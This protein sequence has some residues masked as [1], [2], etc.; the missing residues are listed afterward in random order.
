MALQNMSA[1]RVEHIART[2]APAFEH[3]FSI[4]QE[5]VAKHQNK[6]EVIKLRGQWVNIDPTA[7]KTRRDAKISVGVGAGNKD[8]MLANLNLTFQK[9]M[10]LLPL[11]MATP[12]SIHAT[13]VEE[14]KLQGFSNPLK[15]WPDPK[16]NPPPPPQ[17]PPE[18]V[19]A[20]ME[21]QADQQ[22]FQAQA[23]L[24]QQKAQQDAALAQQEAQQKLALEREKAQ[25]QAELERYKAELQAQT[26]LQMKQMELGGQIQIKEAEFG[27][28][29]EVKGA[30]LQNTRDLAVMQASQPKEDDGK[31][32]LK[33]AMEMMA[34]AME[35]M[36][37]PKKVDRDANG[38]VIGVSPA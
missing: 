6:P 2:M 36:N 13:L 9:Q 32:D 27:L 16:Q 10:A 37:R 8:S 35:A 12:E 11:G 7:W 31:E 20:Q 21:L 4:I 23:Q 29:R 17:P 30:E 19:K 24:D 26:Q 28:Q 18:I 14:M 34:K 15:H 33:A 5:L 22:K 3:L 1:Q 38:R 25:L